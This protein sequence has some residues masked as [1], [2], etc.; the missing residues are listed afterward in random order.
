MEEILLN[1]NCSEAIVRIDLRGLNIPRVSSL[2]S[3]LEKAIGE[4]SDTWINEKTIF[5][6]PVLTI[7]GNMPYNDSETLNKIIDRYTDKYE[8]EDK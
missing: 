5:G 8:Y 2:F 1:P 4:D 7:D 3:E 6:I